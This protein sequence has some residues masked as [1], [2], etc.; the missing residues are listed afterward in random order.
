MACRIAHLNL[1]SLKQYLVRTVELFPQEVLQALPS[2]TGACDVTRYTK[3]VSDSMAKVFAG[4]SAMNYGNLLPA[5]GSA[6]KCNEP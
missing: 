6:G 3:W 4:A 5:I 2:V 1:E